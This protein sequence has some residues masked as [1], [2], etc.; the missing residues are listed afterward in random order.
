[1]KRI[2]YVLISMA[3][4]AFI[5]CSDSSTDPVLEEEEKISESGEIT[6]EITGDYEV[7]KNGHSKLLGCRGKQFC[8]RQRKFMTNPDE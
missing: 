1:M 5:S 3:L 6:L 4:V 2:N 7:E 8:K